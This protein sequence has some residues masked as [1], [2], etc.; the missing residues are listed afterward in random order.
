MS[1]TIETHALSSILI[2]VNHSSI[3]S[4]PVHFNANDS[5]D[6]QELSDLMSYEYTVSCKW[7]TPNVARAI[8]QIIAQYE[9][10]NQPTVYTFE[11]PIEGQENNDLVTVSPVMY[12]YP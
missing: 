2:E 9:T 7:L 5:E 8:S 11:V 6:M 12:V 3:A 4:F 1:Y 10:G